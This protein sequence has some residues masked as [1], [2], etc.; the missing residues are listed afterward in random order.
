MLGDAARRLEFSLGVGLTWL[1][2]EEFDLFSD[3]DVL[4]Q[5]SL[6]A[7]VT[8]WKN[9]R[10]SVL[11]VVGGDYGAAGSTTRGTPTHL[12]FVGLLLGGELRAHAFSGLVGYGRVLAG[13]AIIASRVGPAGGTD[14]LALLEPAVAV[15]GNLGAAAR[16]YGSRN[17]PSRSFRLEAYVQGGYDFVSEVGLVYQAGP[18]GPLRPEPLDLGVLSAGGPTF[19]FGLQGSY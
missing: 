10:F 19:G 1:G 13:P 2:D 15:S 12:D 17:G 3:S 4:P 8:V 9:G 11:G 7:G 16:L 5:V 6:R 18:D 14:T